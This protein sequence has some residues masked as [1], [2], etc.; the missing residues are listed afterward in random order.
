M[1]NILRFMAITSFLG[2][3]EPLGAR[4]EA[5]A[6]C[7]DFIR[8]PQT[9]HKPE[10]TWGSSSAGW[11]SRL[12]SRPLPN[13]RGSLS[14]RSGSSHASGVHCQLGISFEWG[15]FTRPLFVHRLYMAPVMYAYLK[16][17]MFGVLKLSIGVI[18]GKTME[19]DRAF[20]DVK[21][22][23]EKRAQMVEPFLLADE[24]FGRSRG[25]PRRDR[26]HGF[27]PILRSHVLQATLSSDF[28]QIKMQSGEAP[29]EPKWLQASTQISLTSSG[30][31]R[32]PG[33]RPLLDKFRIGSSPRF[34]ATLGQVPD[35]VES[36]I[37]GYSWTSSGL[38]RVPGS[39][40]LLDNFRIGSSPRS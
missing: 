31:G 17:V 23:H 2:A 34:E 30:L 37:R 8:H 21:A 40:L 11:R 6:R 10:E 14:R 39:R 29:T 22:D 12:R 16:L 25:A 3:C 33:S 5:G 35:W 15:D 7:V 28:V 24:V 27:A 13:A 38:G 26:G 32:I 9:I 36:Q 20:R 4:I 19:A 18:V 1:V